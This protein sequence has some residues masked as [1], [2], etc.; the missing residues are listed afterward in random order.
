MLLKSINKKL[1]LTHL[2]I[3]LLLFLFSFL[4]MYLY[5]PK[6]AHTVE[7]TCAINIWWILHKKCQSVKPTGQKFFALE[8]APK[9]VHVWYTCDYY[10]LRGVK[11]VLNPVWCKIKDWGFRTSDLGI[12]I[13]YQD[14]KYFWISDLF[15]IFPV[16]GSNV[17]GPDCM[18]KHDWSWSFSSFCSF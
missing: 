14:S 8:F 18:T 3:D 15:W 9:V 2:L 17:A 6:T 1:R 16:F 10:E 5:C 7:K 11:V 12:L 13:F 4:K